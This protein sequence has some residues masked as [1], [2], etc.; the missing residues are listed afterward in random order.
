MGGRLKARDRHRLYEAAVQTPEVEVELLGRAYQKRF[1]APAVSL[2]EDFCGTALLAK[3]WVES[4]D[5]RVAWGVDLDLE[6]LAYGRRHHIE[7]LDEDEAD[8]IELHAEDARLRSERTFDVIT[9]GNFSWALFDDKAL[10]E[11]LTSAYDCLE[12]RGLLALEI[13]GGADLRRP[14]LHEH[15][16][17]GFDYLW[18][19]NA[20][21]EETCRLEASIH[22]RAKDGTM[23]RDAFRYSFQVRGWNETRTLVTA[24]GFRKVELWV[25]RE[26]GGFVCQADE[27][28]AA[29]WSGYVMAYKG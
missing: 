27:P 22:F 10:S 2:R 8:R 24:A 11:Y 28:G 5:D 18:E 12:D 13:F 19:Q 9:A 1:E 7:P 16:K 21:D 29:A 25:E 14:L 4:D 17:D 26:G 15:T 3:T 20:Y 23:L 6:V